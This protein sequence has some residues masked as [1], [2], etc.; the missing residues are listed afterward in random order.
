MASALART[1]DEAGLRRHPDEISRGRRAYRL[2]AG[3]RRTGIAV[4][5]Q[6][7]A[8]APRSASPRSRV[9][10]TTRCRSRTPKRRNTTA[11]SRHCGATRTASILAG[12]LCRSSGSKPRRA[13]TITPIFRPT[14]P[15]ITARRAFPR[16]RVELPARRPSTS[17]DA[18]GSPRPHPARRRHVLEVNT[19]PGMTTAG[20]A[21][22]PG[23]S[24]A[25]LC[26]EIRGAMWMTKT[27]AIAATLVVLLRRWQGRD[28][29]GRTGSPRSHGK[30]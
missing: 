16:R 10:T 18:A 23:M 5:R 21:W 7:R 29:Y 26:V 15:S 17:S 2:D 6:A 14:T 30:R 12:A 28:P 22:R 9:S 20:Y 24:F 1:S 19:S 4:D 27:G 8:R 3:R 11:L 25:D 13:T